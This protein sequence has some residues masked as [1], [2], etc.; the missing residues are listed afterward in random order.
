M[1]ISKDQVEGRARQAAGKIQEMAGRIVG[2]PIQ[3]VKG[4]IKKNIGKAQATFGDL[5][6]DAKN[7]NARDSK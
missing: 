2:N 1:S 4:K 6:S 3:E 7:S 5:E